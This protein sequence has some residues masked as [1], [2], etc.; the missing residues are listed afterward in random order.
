MPFL[1]IFHVSRG[2]FE[3]FG[4][5]CEGIPT[6]PRI[7]AKRGTTRQIHK[8]HLRQFILHDRVCFPSWSSHT[9]VLALEG[10]CRGPSARVT[11]RGPYPISEGTIANLAMLLNQLATVASVAVDTLAALLKVPLKPEPLDEHANWMAQ[12]GHSRRTWVGDGTLGIKLRPRSGCHDK[13]QGIF[14]AA[15]G[16]PKSANTSMGAV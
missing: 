15:S 2:T 13:A 11:G 6:T 10:L 8:D 9:A 1:A 7:S 4:D 3:Q 16:D 5:V 14:C 12:G